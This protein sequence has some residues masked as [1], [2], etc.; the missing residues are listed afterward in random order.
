[1]KYKIIIGATA[2]LFCSGFVTAQQQTGLYPKR[3][4]TYM[5][6]KIYANTDINGLQTIY[7]SLKTEYD[8]RYFLSALPDFFKE[9][10]IQSVPGWVSA[11]VINAF[12]SNDP[13]C[14]LN[15]VRT[16]GSLKI[17]C[18]GQLVALYKT[19]S[20]TF[21]S[22]KDMIITAIFGAL[23]GMDNPSKSIFLNDVLTND[24]F[25]LLSA[26]FSSLI[27][28]METAKSPMYTQKLA[29][30]SDSLNSLKTRLSAA[31]E[32]SY[33]LQECLAMQ[34]KVNKLMAELGGN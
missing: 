30:F 11:A 17:N 24:H 7:D 1:M 29:V 9:R 22:H 15:A 18:Y 6:R 14:V 10:N 31:T 25:P 33:K 23:Y 8:R 27:S 26:S 28:A 4:L 2:L 5:E 13:L 3:A 20:T 16:S 19:G 21:G 32:R 12:A 34:N